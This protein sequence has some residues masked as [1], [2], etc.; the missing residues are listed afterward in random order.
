MKFFIYALAIIALIGILCTW[1][2][3]A[4]VDKIDSLI[5]TLDEAKPQG[6]SVPPNANEV[7]D[8]LSKKWEKDSFLISMLLPHHHLDEVKEKLVTLKAYATTDEFAEW[9]D[10]SLVLKEE[11]QHIRGL[12]GVSADNVL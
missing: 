6:E 9:R 5:R 10:A 12:L 11:L 3:I 8:R 7:V 2:T 1:G 4:S